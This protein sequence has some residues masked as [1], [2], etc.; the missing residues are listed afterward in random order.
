M[1]I[2]PV[3]YIASIHAHLLFIITKCHPIPSKP[4]YIDYYYNSLVVI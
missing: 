2:K 1:I 3:Y 4:K